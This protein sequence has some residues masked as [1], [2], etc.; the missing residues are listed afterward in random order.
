MDVV[1]ILKR[2]KA[3]IQKRNDEAIASG[4]EALK[5]FNTNANT[6]FDN[7]TQL[8]QDFETIYKYHQLLIANNLPG[9]PSS[10]LTY[11]QQAISQADNEHS[12]WERQADTLQE[13]INSKLADYFR[14]INKLQLNITSIEGSINNLE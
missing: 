10:T 9:Y 3:A 7:Y 4:K 2:Q 5:I 6:A 11:F 8:S 13:R 1:A 12:Y 14:E